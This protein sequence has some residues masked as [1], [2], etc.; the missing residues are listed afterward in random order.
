MSTFANRIKSLRIEKGLTG[1][2]LSAMFNQTKSA[3]SSWER[4]DRTPSQETLIT[5]AVYFEVS[6]DYLLGMSDVRTPI[7]DTTQSFTIDLV[8]RLLKENIISDI[9]NIPEEITDMI[10]S[11]LRADLKKKSK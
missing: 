7:V 2:E 6:L 11:S 10:I 3:V 9:D 8:N 1:T 4:R 5:L